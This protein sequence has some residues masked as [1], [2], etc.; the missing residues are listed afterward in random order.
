[1][2]YNL[3]S[4]LQSFPADFFRLIHESLRGL[5]APKNKNSMFNLSK[6]IISE[7]RQDPSM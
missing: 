7:Y 1:M 3:D 2:R 6:G 5:S 4:G